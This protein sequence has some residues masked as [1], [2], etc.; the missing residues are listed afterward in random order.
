MI[1]VIIQGTKDIEK[2]LTSLS[3]NSKD[4][5]RVLV[6][7]SV[8]SSLSGIYTKIEFVKPSLI[9]KYG[10]KSDYY[11]SIASGCVVLASSWDYRIELAGKDKSG[12]FCLCTPG[13]PDSLITNKRGNVGKWKGGVYPVPCL[14]IFG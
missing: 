11:W 8:R 6:D 3:N 12:T 4:G 7:K 9:S 2:T 5:F 13:R 14:S 1:T 10:K